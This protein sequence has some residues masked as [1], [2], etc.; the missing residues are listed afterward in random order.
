M[1]Q[2]FG[3]C[4]ML[5]QRNTDTRKR[6]LN[7]RRYKVV[8]FSQRSGV[9]E[10]CSGT[11][12]IGEF[13]V[14]PNKGAHK[15]FRPQDWA[16][17][18]CRRKMLDAQRLA[19]DEKLQAYNEVCTKFRPVFRYFCMERFLD[20]AVWMEKRLAYTRSVA[21]SS[22]V[23]YIVGLGDRHIQN[24]LIDEQTAELVHIDLGVAFEQGKILPTPETVPFRLS[25]DIVD[26]M[27][28]TGVEGVFRRCC[29]KTME[30]MRSS[31][32]AL[33]T[34]VEVLLYDPL[35]DWTMNPLKAFYLQHDEQQELNATLSSTMG[36]DDIDNSRKSSSDSQSFNKVAER[37]LLRLQEKLKGVEEGTVLSVG[38][39]VNLLIQQ[40]M[41]PK[42]LSRLF[43]GWQAWV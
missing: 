39:Q 4:S 38:G 32:E 14:E 23:G 22:I 24:I 17:L 42:N 5:L 7:I 2:V 29:E 37:V 13:L 30:V 18:A 27:G 3:M 35:F 28:I 43:P 1:Q 26:G 33:L 10:W 6:K 31:Q 15:R 25:R 11:V 9:L 34:I 19:F 41:D 36:G 20:P 40:A 8:P 21:T 12:P 16:S